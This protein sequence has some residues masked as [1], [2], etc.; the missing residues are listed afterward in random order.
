MRVARP[1]PTAW[2]AAEAWAVVTGA[3]VP[4]TA[5]ADA[6][7]VAVEFRALGAPQASRDPGRVGAARGLWKPT[8]DWNIEVAERQRSAAA[9]ARRMDMMSEVG[10]ASGRIDLARH[11]D[12]RSGAN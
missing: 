6:V 12:V 3:A 1:R 10:M 8:G 7:G 11:M 9:P 5:A 4:R 2:V